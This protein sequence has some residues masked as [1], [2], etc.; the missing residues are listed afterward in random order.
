MKLQ[1]VK[2]NWP[3]SEKLLDEA[4][5]YNRRLWTI[6]VASV[7]Q[8]DN[9]LPREIKQNIINLGMFIFNHTINMQIEPD[10]KRLVVLVNINRE[11][12]AGLRGRVADEAAQNAAAAG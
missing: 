10:P 4:L 3:D 9:P 12:A 1:S 5:A 6:L 7:A 8:E 11:I 2:E